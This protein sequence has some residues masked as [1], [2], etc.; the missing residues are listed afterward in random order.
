MP[1]DHLE[2]HPAWTSE[3]VRESFLEETVTEPNLEKKSEVAKWKGV[4][5]QE[6]HVWGLEAREQ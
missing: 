1:W 2:E 5:A 3:A 6:A 4:P